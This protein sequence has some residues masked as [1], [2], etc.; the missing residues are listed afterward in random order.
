[1]NIFSWKSIALFATE[2]GR[3]LGEAFKYWQELRA[4]QLFTHSVQSSGR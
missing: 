3:C 2:T 1:M 4:E